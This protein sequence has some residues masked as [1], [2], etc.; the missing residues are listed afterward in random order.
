MQILVLG[1]AGFLGANLVRRALEEPGVSVTVLDS[2]DP[3]FH[4]TK[5]SL[6][7]VWDQIEFVRGDIRDENPRRPSA[8]VQEWENE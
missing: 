2:L 7:E 6:R 5:D 1:G 4:S 3:R 8:N